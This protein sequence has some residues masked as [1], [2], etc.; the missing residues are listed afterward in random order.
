MASQ[1]DLV[2]RAGTIVDGTGAAPYV[3]DIGVKDGIITEIGDI[4]ARGSEEIDATGRTITPGFVD[5][6]TQYDGQ[7]TWESPMASSCPI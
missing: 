3:A 2:I 6:H 1:F 7:I 5:V 4:S